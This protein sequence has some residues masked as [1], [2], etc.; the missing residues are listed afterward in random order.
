[1]TVELVIKIEYEEQNI[2]G[3]KLVASIESD[4]EIIAG[5][6]DTPYD[7]LRGLVDELEYQHQY[8]RADE[9]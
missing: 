8:F 2:E 1:M 5:Y 9:E 7:A 3:G 4:E 6:G